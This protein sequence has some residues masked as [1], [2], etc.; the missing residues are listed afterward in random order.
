MSLALLLFCFLHVQPSELETASC[1]VMLHWELN[2]HWPSYVVLEKR[3][4]VISLL[5]AVVVVVVVF[6]FIAHF[7]RAYA[8]AQYASLTVKQNQRHHSRNWSAYCQEALRDR[9]EQGTIGKQYATHAHTR[10]NSD[11]R[12]KKQQRIVI[13]LCAC[14][15][16]V[17][18]P[19][20]ARLHL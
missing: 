8:V 5:I 3:R 12:K 4:T 14:V 10:N 11:R 16:L 7:G 17:L 18:L 1:V 19:S 15:S 2:S 20:C 9:R 6:W 13:S